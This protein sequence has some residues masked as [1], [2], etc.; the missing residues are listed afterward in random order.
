MLKAQS[1]MLNA[2]PEE[3]QDFGLRALRFHLDTGH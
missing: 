3:T 2:Q 1:A